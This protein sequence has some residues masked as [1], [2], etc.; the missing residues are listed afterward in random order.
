MDQY[1]DDKYSNFVNPKGKF[2]LLDYKDARGHRI[3]EFLVCILYPKNP[4]WVIITIGNTIF[5]AL[6]RER[7]VDWVTIVRDVV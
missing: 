7:K 1:L 2:A 6:S 5:G 3:L 4:T